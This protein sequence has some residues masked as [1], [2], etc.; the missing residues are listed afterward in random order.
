MIKLP[1]ASICQLFGFYDYAG[2]AQVA[3]QLSLRLR[4]NFDVTLVCRKITRKIEEDIKIVELKPKNTL[5]LW[6]ILDRLLEEF[7]IIHSHDVYS[8]PGLLRKKRTAK[9]IYTDHGIVP[10]KYSRKESFQGFL[11]AHFCRFFARRS[12]LS[13]GIS[14]YIV[15]EL[16][17]KVG[18]SNV[19]KIPNGVDTERFRPIGASEKY[20]KL[21]LGNPML[22]KVGLIEKHKAVD[23]HIA[24]MPFILKKFPRAHM[25]FIGA[26][27][28]INYYKTLV[29]DMKLDR[30]IHFLGWMPSQMLPL[31]YNASDII[32]Q[33]DYFHGFGLPMLEGMACG[34]PIIA[35]DAYAM[36]EHILKSGAGVL[37][38]GKDPRELAS[39]VE[40]ILDNY[41]SYAS[42]AREYAKRFDWERIAAQYEEA[43]KKVL[44]N[45]SVESMSCSK[46]TI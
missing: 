15:N 46:N 10:L 24:S 2:I 35:R 43:Y 40:H 33:A 30:F 18:C 5:E 26:G 25:V 28:D 17:Y 27:R 23:Y 29:R 41:D 14:D 11:F 16:K 32:L 45:N 37:V 9:I 13:I 39:A 31:Y 4:K 6:K 1:K 20:L 3:V 7:D 44:S 12:D 19:M 38:R 22:L 21:K 42:K 36:R 8:L 34:K